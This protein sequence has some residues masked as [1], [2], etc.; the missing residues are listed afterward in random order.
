MNGVEL[1]RLGMQR[2]ILR[3]LSLRLDAIEMV[4]KSSIRRSIEF[5]LRQVDGKCTDQAVAFAS[6]SAYC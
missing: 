3:R 2:R 6:H 1:S 4:L 5:E